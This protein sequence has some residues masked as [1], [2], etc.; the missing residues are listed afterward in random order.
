MSI[1]AGGLAEE[2]GRLEGRGPGL[3]AAAY[4]HLAGLE[5]RFEAERDQLPLWLPVGLILGIALWFW[6]PDRW[7]WIAFLAFSLA[8]ALALAAFAGATRVGRALAIF[9]FAAAS[10]CGLIWWK[11]EQSAAP[12]LERPRMLEFEGKVETV[13]ALAAERTLRLVVAPQGEWEGEG[14]PAR[15]RIN[16]SEENETAASGRLE[17]G[18]VVRVRAWMMPPPP[19][20]A[21]G[22]YDFARTAWFQRIGGTGRA[23]SIVVVTPAAEQGWQARIADWR[24]RLA[25][26]I[27]ERLGG[28]PEGGI[29]A[30]LATGDQ[31]GIPE[32]DAEAMRRSGLAHL[33][34]V[35]GLHLTAVVGA[36]MLMTL[37]LLA[38]SPAL[39]LRCRLVLV[40]AAAGALAGIGYTLLTGA[41]VP[42]MRACI[43]ALLVLAGIALGRDAL[44]LRLLAVGALFVLLLWPESLVGPSFQ[45][46][47]AAIAAIVALHEH[48]RIQA[49]LSRRDEGSLAA[50]GRFLLALALTGLAVELALTPIALFHFHRSGLY[51]AAANIVAIPLTTFVI[52]PLEAL[53]LLLDPIGLSAPFWWLAGR[54]LSFLVWLA[55]AA[56]GAPGAVALLPAMPRGA[57]ALLVAGG[58]WICLWRTRWRRL[59]LV[60]VGVG[61]AWALATPAPDLIVT[62]DGRHL[63]LRT[64]GGGL[65]L[66]RPRAGDYV[67]D[68]LAELAGAEPDYLDLESLPTAAC[69]RDLCVADLD[70]GGRRWRILA[71]RSAHFV[72]WDQMVRA[73]AE[74]DIVV[75]DRMLPRGCVPRWLKADRM[76]L[77]R[78]GGIAVKL[79]SGPGIDTVAGQV[80]RHPWA[81]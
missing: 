40:A 81:P 6:L 33:L 67:R 68:T 32:A 51:G 19:M 14:R 65:A 47:F 20:A 27:R 35:S 73:C 44:T 12:R 25:A 42:T 11:A 1:D 56:A 18:A 60:P 74:A 50:M 4:R 57:F 37:K 36:V 21:P 76:L 61:A 49:L 58:L 75:A 53:A 17:P 55:H 5:R 7:A 54:T 66:L 80:G 48:P 8:T 9:A 79:D 70:R 3:G 16:V 23:N 10:G 15:L 26:H 45:L 64:D 34:S 2:A 71:T 69:S 72:R 63:V 31:H 29:A 22:G 52:M 30:A 46:S 39:A 43:A 38:L 59:G 41:E 77:R 62:G 24:R 28:G 13:Q 78:T